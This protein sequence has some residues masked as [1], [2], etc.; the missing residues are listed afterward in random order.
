ME[1]LARTFKLGVFMLGLVLVGC[2]HTE[3]YQN[4][5]KTVLPKAN[6]TVLLMPPDILVQELTASGL[7]LTNAAWARSRAPGLL[8]TVPEMSTA[9]YKSS[10]SLIIRRR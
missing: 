7:T 10:R 5:N 3:S 1:R 2:T 6:P 9:V 8:K 4:V